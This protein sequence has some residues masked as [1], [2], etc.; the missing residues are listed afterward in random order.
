MTISR[1]HRT[2]RERRATLVRKWHR[3]GRTCWLCGG[4]L[5]YTTP[6]LPNSVE[7]DHVLAIAAGGHVLGPLEPACRRC[8]QS[9]GAKSPEEYRALLAGEQ[10]RRPASTRRTTSWGNNNESLRTIPPM[11]WS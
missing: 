3:E 10:A 9:R 5:N 2:F 6:G 8:N 1:Q 4:V 11:K 7:A